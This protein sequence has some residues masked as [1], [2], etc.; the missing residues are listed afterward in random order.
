MSN[1]VFLT[2]NLVIITCSIQSFKIMQNLI[3]GRAMD[4]S[5]LKQS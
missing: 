5:S 3:S 2:S 1:R 4:P